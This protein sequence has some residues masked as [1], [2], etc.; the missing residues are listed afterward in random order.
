[1]PKS[2]C[3]WKRKHYIFRTYLRQKWICLCQTKSRTITGP[4]YTYCRIH[5]TGK[6]ASF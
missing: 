6:N 1:M 3:H 2:Q 4:I 5:F